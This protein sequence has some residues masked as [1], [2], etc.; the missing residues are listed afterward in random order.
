MPRETLASLREIIQTR[1]DQILAF[2]E[3][4]KSR[5][6]QVE[7][8]KGNAATWR[9]DAKLAQAEVRRL[10][11][12]ASEMRGFIMAHHSTE[13]EDGGETY[14]KEPYG[15]MDNEDNQ[16]TMPIMKYPFMDAKLGAEV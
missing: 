16:V 14:Y 7:T 11:L 3:E 4:L 9:A 10:E 8:I 15:N 5:E 6:A 13:V 2:D 1:D 12:L